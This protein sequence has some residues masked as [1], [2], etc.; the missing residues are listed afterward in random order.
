MAETVR[1]DRFAEAWSDLLQIIATMCSNL[2]CPDCATH[3][4][5]YLAAHAD[6]R[7]A[8]TKDALR[9]A[10]CAFHNSVNARKGRFPLFDPARL[11]ETY[12]SVNVTAAAA[13]A[14]FFFQSRH[15]APPGML[16]PHT[17]ARDRVAGMVR[18]WIAANADK[19]FA[20]AAAAGVVVAV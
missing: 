20:A 4:T 19:L 2:P 17:L 11:G 1:E 14:L 9:Q 18:V 7:E 10:L 3:A 13:R 12:G 6:L 8:K 5:Q 15:S 16:V